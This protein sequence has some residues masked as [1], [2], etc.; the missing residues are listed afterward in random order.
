M[1]SVDPGKLQSMNINHIPN[2]DNSDFTAL[3][4]SIVERVEGTP[5]EE[6]REKLISPALLGRSIA[7]ESLLIAGKKIN[8]E[9][10]DRSIT[11]G[12]MN[13]LSIALKTFDPTDAPWESAMHE[14]VVALNSAR[15]ELSKI[16]RSAVGEVVTAEQKRLLGARISII[17]GGSPTTSSRGV[18]SVIYAFARANG[19][20]T[21]QPT[22]EMAWAALAHGRHTSSLRRT[23]WRDQVEEG[24]AET[25]YPW[26]H[27]SA[28]SP[29]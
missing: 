14:S 18:P 21:S 25:G 27:R 5:V 9:S 24:D 8:L 17:A 23:E 29:E 10:L 16:E 11:Q 19:R 15:Q 7:L 20:F 4:L 2:L 26:T 22:V 12:A 28:N 3:L 13:L 1:A 6:L